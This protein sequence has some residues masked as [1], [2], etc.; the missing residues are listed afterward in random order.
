L[1]TYESPTFAEAE[2]VRIFNTEAAE[3]LRILDLG[4]ESIKDTLRTL[5]RHRADRQKAL[6]SYNAVLS[7]FRRLPTELL[8]EVFVYCL[9]ENDAPTR[10]CAPLLLMGVCKRWRSVALSTPR[11]W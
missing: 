10:R 6:E 7:P 2:A 1:E 11:L 8:V 9:P 5:E 4:L 3:Q